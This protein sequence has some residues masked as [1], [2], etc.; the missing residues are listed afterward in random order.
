MDINEVTSNDMLEFSR[1]NNDKYGRSYPLKI[2]LIN[3]ESIFGHIVAVSYT[4]DD[5]EIGL[6][7]QIENLDDWNKNKIQAGTKGLSL[8]TQ[9][10][11]DI[12]VHTDY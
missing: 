10:I 3:G 11:K 6:F 12:S 1:T 2:I 4:G 7:K 5:F 9:D 8:T